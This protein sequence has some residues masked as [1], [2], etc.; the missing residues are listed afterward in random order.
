VE[1]SPKTNSLINQAVSN[2]SEKN[3]E[4]YSC[5]NSLP[6]KSQNAILTSLADMSDMGSNL[7]GMH[8]VILG[9][10]DLD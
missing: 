2:S 7:Y 10:H 1:K 9:F 5:Q 8:I 6:Q 4:V 3:F